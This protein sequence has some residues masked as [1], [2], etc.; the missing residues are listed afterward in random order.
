MKVAGKTG[1]AVRLIITILLAAA[2]VYTGFIGRNAYAE[3]NSVVAKYEST[4]V[5]DDLKNST[6]AGE[7]FDL[8]DYPYK[9]NGDAQLITFVEYCYS[10]VKDKQSDYGLYAYIYNPQQ[11]AYDESDINK[12]QF[13]FGNTQPEKYV[14]YT[15]RALNYSTQAGYEGLFWKF[16]VELTPEQ[17]RLILAKISPS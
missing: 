2:L 17:R 10:P 4:N 15:L 8:S 3:E 11:T 1:G 16:K 7:A 6:I 9:A 13:C 12:I 14:K 5:L